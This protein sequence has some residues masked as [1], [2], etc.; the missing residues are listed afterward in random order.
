MIKYLVV[1]MVFLFSGV[2]FGADSLAGSDSIDAILSFLAGIPALGSFLV[3]FL[4]VVGIVAGVLTLAT[5]VI[6]FIALMLRVFGKDSAWTVRVNEII[7]KIRP[8][9]AYISVYNVQKKA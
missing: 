1:F 5:A 2:C 9:V 4:K 7:A 6:D 8:Y 3:T